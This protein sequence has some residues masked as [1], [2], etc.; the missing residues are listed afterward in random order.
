MSVPPRV[1]FIRE[2]TFVLYASFAA[3]MTIPGDLAGT[4]PAGSAS[5]DGNSLSGEAGYRLGG[6]VG[7]TYWLNRVWGASL[8]LGFDHH[9][10]LCKAVRLETSAGEF[11]RKFIS[12]WL[13]EPVLQ[14]GSSIRW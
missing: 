5:N 9:F 8:A 7:W 6:S 11:E 14:A 10:F 3:G 2:P 13:S 12:V 1:F 4:I